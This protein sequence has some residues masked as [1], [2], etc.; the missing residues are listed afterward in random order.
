MTPHVLLLLLLAAAPASGPGRDPFVSP[1]SVLSDPS[2]GLPGMAWQSLQVT[3]IVEAPSG[4]IATLSS[5][6][7]DA[8]VAQEGDRLANAVVASIDR[9]RKTVV[10]RMPAADS[11]AGFRE[12]VL[13]MGVK[14][15]IVRE[16]HA[17]EPLLKAK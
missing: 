14:D 11:V 2:K 17:A 3:G 1:Q 10:L 12:V 4:P 6:Q 16:P 8:F 5:D 13:Q 15:A 7:G 9:A